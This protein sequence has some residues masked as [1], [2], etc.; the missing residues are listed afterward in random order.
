[1]KINM[2]KIIKVVTRAFCAIGVLFVMG[3]IIF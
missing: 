3:A 2:R 1:M